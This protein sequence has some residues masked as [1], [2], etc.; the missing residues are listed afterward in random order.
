MK[1]SKNLFSLT[2]FSIAFGLQ[3]PAVAGP[4]GPSAYLCFDAAMIAGC[5]ASD[6]PFKGIDFSGGY[7]HFEDFED[8]ALNTPGQRPSTAFCSYCTVA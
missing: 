4:I 5:G 1:F 8:A 6:S 2:L 7:F 3:T